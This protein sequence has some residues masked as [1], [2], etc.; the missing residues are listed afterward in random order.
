MLSRLCVIYAV[1]SSLRN[2]IVNFLSSMTMAAWRL[3]SPCRQLAAT[4]R[5]PRMFYSKLFSVCT[6]ELAIRGVSPLG[7]SDVGVDGTFKGPSM[8]TS[9]PG[10]KTKVKI[11]HFLAP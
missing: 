11:N 6:S 5:L 9:I 8:N 7:F 4:T 2:Q 3:L 10:P 1:Q